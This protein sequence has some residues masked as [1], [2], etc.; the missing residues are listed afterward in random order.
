MGH[1]FAIVFAFF[2]I[3]FCP[4]ISA[5]AEED[6]P[7]NVDPV[8]CKVAKE[9]GGKVYVGKPEDVFREMR[10]DLEKPVVPAKPRHVYSPYSK[11]LGCS[12]IFDVRGKEICEAVSGNLEWRWTGHAVI[13]P[14]WKFDFG[15]LKKVYCEAK[16]SK[17]DLPLLM[18]MCTDY[19]GG[20]VCTNPSDPRLSMALEWL[21]SLIIARDGGDDFTKGTVFEPDSS[22]YVLKDGCHVR[23]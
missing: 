19:D 18:K 2:M 23:K 11:D 13:A 6:C 9:T 5:A 14:G 10:E 8:Y 12:E 3:A 1:V 17:D 15:G 4:A 21:K 20:R 22:S 16:I 7:A